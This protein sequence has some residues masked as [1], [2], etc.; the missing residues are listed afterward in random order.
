M[1]TMIFTGFYK[2]GPP[3][4]GRPLPI[5]QIKSKLIFPNIYIKK[6]MK[7][8]LFQFHN[9]PCQCKLTDNMRYSHRIFTQI[10][11]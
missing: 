11:L 8:E 7:Y 5:K 4:Y 9:T 3:Y 2:K 1:L 6:Y 10:F